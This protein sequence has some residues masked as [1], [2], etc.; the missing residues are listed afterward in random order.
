MNYELFLP[1]HFLVLIQHAV[2]AAFL[3]RLTVV[4]MY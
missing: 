1:S 2:D 4:D 3:H